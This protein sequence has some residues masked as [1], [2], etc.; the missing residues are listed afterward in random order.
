MP[1]VWHITSRQSTTRVS[2]FTDGV[3]PSANSGAQKNL[4]VSLARWEAA[5]KR[6]PVRFLVRKSEKCATAFAG[7]DRQ[8]GFSGIAPR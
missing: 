6:P 4:A 1:K 2:P 3:T 8:P 7:G 5:G